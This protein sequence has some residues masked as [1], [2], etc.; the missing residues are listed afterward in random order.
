MWEKTAHN[1]TITPSTKLIVLVGKA[2]TIE[3]S[4][5]GKEDNQKTGLS[6]KRLGGGGAGKEG[7]GG[8]PG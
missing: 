1:L 7:G 5:L 6:G 3:K 2:G 4:L 8:S